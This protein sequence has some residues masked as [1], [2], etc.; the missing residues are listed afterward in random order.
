MTGPQLH[1]IVPGALDQRTGGYIYDTQ[2]VEG[3]RGRGWVVVVHELAS[4]PPTVDT[5]GR[6]SLAETLLRLPDGAR[7][8]IDGLAMGDSPDVVRAH[9]T[10]LKVLALVHHLLADETG[11]EPAQRDRA[12]E[13]EREALAASTGVVVTSSFTASRLRSIGV[14][15]ALIRTG[16]ASTPI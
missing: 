3:L 13:R 9:G 6:A 15:S 5:P 7:V 10:R 11:L 2:V 1:F 14:E 12:L 16:T 8:V 4:E